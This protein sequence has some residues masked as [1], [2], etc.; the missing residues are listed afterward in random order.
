MAKDFD[1]KIPVIDVMLNELFGWQAQRQQLIR[2]KIDIYEV[3]LTR[4]LE[5]L[6]SLSVEHSESKMSYATWP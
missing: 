6:E 5:K 1:F 3:G 4:F 2:R